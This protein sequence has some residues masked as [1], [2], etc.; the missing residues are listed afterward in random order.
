MST[1]VAENVI[2]FSC[3]THLHGR[4]GGIMNSPPPPTTPLS[5][6]LTGPWVAPA[7]AGY[8]KA[9]ELRGEGLLGGSWAVEWWRKRKSPS[10]CNANCS[11]KLAFESTLCCWKLVMPR[12]TRHSN[13]SIYQ[14]SPLVPRDCSAQDLVKVT[15]P[16]STGA[17]SS[18]PKAFPWPSRS[19]ACWNNSRGKDTMKTLTLR[20]CE[21]LGDYLCF[22]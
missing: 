2:N 8:S 20:K 10:F 14:C 22:S 11:T 4:D 1:A 13:G 16:A 18:H 9:G 6:P 21:H 19:S 12:R 17:W 7:N 15:P 5:T 3:L